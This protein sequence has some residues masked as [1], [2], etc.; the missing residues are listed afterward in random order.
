M[1]NKNLMPEKFN[2]KEWDNI[3]NI[4]QDDAGNAFYNLANSLIIDD[5]INPIF[6]DE[7][8]SN[9][10]DNLYHISHKFYDDVTLWW[11]IAYAN[12]LVNPFDL[13]NKKLKILKKSIVNQIINSLI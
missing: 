1:K 10:Y 11:F 13:E 7:Y 12:D 2:I 8:S 6:Y 5:D 4:H 9:E 3:F